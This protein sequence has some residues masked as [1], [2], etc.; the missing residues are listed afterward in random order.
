MKKTI[1]MFIVSIFLL[2]G[3]GPKELSSEDKQK[4]EQLKMELSQ[5]ENEISSASANNQNYS[6][7]LIKNLISARMEILKTNQALIRQRIDAIES[8][9]KIT[10]DIPGTK[11]D[12]AASEV[13]KKEMNSL[14][15]QISQAKEE[16]NK[17]SGGLVLAMK[18]AAIATQEQTLAML[19]QRYLSAKYGLANSVQSD[20]QQSNVVGTSQID[21]SAQAS[22]TQPLLP[23]G[24]G[25]FGLESGLTKKN[26]EDMIGKELKPFENVPNLYT[27]QSL[28]KKNADFEAYGLLISPKSGLCEI[29]ALG[30]SIDTDSYGL[31]LQSKYKEL[32]DSLSSIY[33]RP[34]K[35]DLLLSGSIWKEP[36]DWMMALN[37]KERFLSAQWKGT[38]TAP[39][40]NNLVS[41]S[42]E[43]RANNSSK[44]Y[45]YLQYDFNNIDA[46]NSEIEDAK[47]SSL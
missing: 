7:G 37:K 13:I 41:V 42:M 18:L 46:C 8:G 34:E 15:A 2:T 16:A 1:M 21:N 19:Q 10:M 43:A 28:P 22:N 47:K 29:R 32:L 44:G 20:Y 36:Q 31:A 30:I 38:L 45:I 12:E 11:S 6:G 35:N 14:N 23:P 5:T 25:P 39:F 24:V 27:S 17:Y 3:C 33:G 9:A 26:I 4:V 40:K